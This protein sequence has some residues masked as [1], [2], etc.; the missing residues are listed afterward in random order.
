MESLYYFHQITSKK[1]RTNVWSFDCFSVVW[2]SNHVIELLKEII[3]NL[4]LF[5][6]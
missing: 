1:F 2:I 3:V 4:I 5:L 6:S